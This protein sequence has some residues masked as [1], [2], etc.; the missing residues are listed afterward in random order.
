MA[1]EIVAP[2]ALS[3]TMNPLAEGQCSI[4]KGGK[5]TIRKADLDLAGIEHYAI[6][7]ADR[8]TFRIGVRA[9]RGEDERPRSVAVSIV[10]SGKGKKDSG[11]RTLS[12]TRA[13]KKVDLRPEAVAGRYELIV[14]GKTSDAMLIISLMPATS[15]K[16]KGEK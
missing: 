11:R 9:V 8:E 1:F 3:N 10:T 16:P 13:I 7:L 15:G 4:A 12:L 2:G 6:V 5:L 14:R